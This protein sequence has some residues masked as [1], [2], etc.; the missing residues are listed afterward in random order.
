MYPA[1]FATTIPVSGPPSEPLE[2]E[3]RGPVHFDAVATVVV[4][5]LNIVGPQ[6]AYFGQKDAQQA[7]VIIAAGARPRHPG[8]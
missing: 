1:G 7:L 6:I 3:A 2:G 8:R 4:K 5:L